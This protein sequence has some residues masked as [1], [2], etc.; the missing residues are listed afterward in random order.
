MVQRNLVTQHK[1]AT[2]DH[3]EAKYGVRYRA[4]RVPKKVGP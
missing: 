2:Q 4:D 3:S 1:L